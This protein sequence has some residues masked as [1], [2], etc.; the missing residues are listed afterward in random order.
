MDQKT[1]QG[2]LPLNCQMN[3]RKFLNCLAA[4]GVLASL[5]G[6]LLKPV[7]A[8]AAQHFEDG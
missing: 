7:Q 4:A 6:G 2:K 5:P 8:A 1:D 3:R